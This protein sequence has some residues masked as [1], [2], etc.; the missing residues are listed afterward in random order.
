MEDCEDKVVATGRIY[1]LL[2]VKREND[3]DD[4]WNA[5]MHVHGVE[6]AAAEEAAAASRL[7]W[8]FNMRR[9]T[10]PRSMA[11]GRWMI[12]REECLLG[13]G[14]NEAINA[15]RRLRPNIQ[16][17][18][19]VRQAGGRG[20]GAGASVDE[21]RD[22]DWAQGKGEQRS[23]YQSIETFVH[24]KSGPPSFDVIPRT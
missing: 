11:R 7:P 3:L 24:H 5:G 14:K 6:D 23:A 16:C 21:T 19:S 18:K 2:V 10:T 17:C 13:D 20:Q 8:P 1:C 9:L 22:R 15:P 12:G 4:V